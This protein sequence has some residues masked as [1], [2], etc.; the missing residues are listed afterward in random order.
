MDDLWESAVEEALDHDTFL[1]ASELLPNMI[2]MH[3][4]GEREHRVIECLVCP[5]GF[6][7]MGIFRTIDSHGYDQT[8][9]YQTN[10]KKDDQQWLFLRWY[11]VD[12]AKR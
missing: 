3:V 11:D 10:G 4:R 12:E 9:L 1:R 2:V 5:D 8:F 7:G 6:D